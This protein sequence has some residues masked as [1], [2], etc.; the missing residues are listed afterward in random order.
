MLHCYQLSFLYR[1]RKIIEHSEN[2]QATVP[3]YDVRNSIRRISENLVRARDKMN[4]KSPP[5]ARSSPLDLLLNDGKGRQIDH[6]EWLTM[7]ID[8]II[9]TILA[10]IP[11]LK[12]RMHSRKRPQKRELISAFVKRNEQRRKDRQFKRLFSAIFNRHRREIDQIVDPVTGKV[13]ADP[14]ELHDAITS[15]LSGWHCLNHSDPETDWQ[16]AISDP[17]YLQSVP[18]LQKVPQP[19]LSKLAKSFTRHSQNQKLRDTMKAAL[20]Q[21]VSYEEY[22]SE[23]RSKANNKSPGL[24]GFTINMLKELPEEVQRHLHLGLCEI[25][26]RREDPTMVPESWYARWIC[27]VPKKKNGPIT[28]DSIR[29][30]SLYEVLRKVW[31][32]IITARISRV[33]TELQVLHPTQYGYQFAMGTDTELLQIINVI[34]DAAEFKKRLILTSFDTT[35]AFDSVNKPLMVAAWC[36]LGVPQ[37]I[38]NYLVNMD[39]GGDTLVK[40]AHAKSV[41][42][43][44]KK[45]QHLRDVKVSGEDAKSSASTVQTFTARDGIG[46]GDSPS[47]NAWIAIYDILLCALDEIEEDP[48]RFQ[49]RD[50]EVSTC[51]AAAYADDLQTFSPTVEHA[52]AAIDIVSAFNCVTGF[53]TNI[54]KMHCGT[55]LDENLG[56]VRV[57]DRHWTG[58]LLPIELEME[59]VILG[60]TID[61]TNRWRTLRQEIAQKTS[62]ISLPLSRKRLSIETKRIAYEMV[63][64]PTILY[65]AK[66][67]NLSLDEYESLLN[68]VNALLRSINR[69]KRTTPEEILYTNHKTAAGL[70][71]SN[72]VSRVQ[73]FKSGMFTRAMRMGNPARQAATAIIE[74]CFRQQAI[75]YSGRA[76]ISISEHN[77]SWYSSLLERQTSCG[78]RL[79]RNSISSSKYASHQPI[80]ELCD[81]KHLDRCD[82]LLAQLDITTVRDLT[83]ET[84]GQPFRRWF[85]DHPVTSLLT[86]FPNIPNN[87]PNILQIGKL[88]LSASREIHEF[89]GWEGDTLYFREWKTRTGKCPSVNDPILLVA[90]PQHWEKRTDAF[91]LDLLAHVYAFGRTNKKG[92]VTSTRIWAIQPDSTPIRQ[93]TV[94]RTP[95]PLPPPSP[96]FFSP[97][98]LFT[99][100]AHRSLLSAQQIVFGVLPCDLSGSSD[101]SSALRIENSSGGV[102]YKGRV[103]IQTLTVTGFDDDSM[104]NSSSYES[105]AIGLLAGLT[106]LG[107]NALKVAAY[108][109]SSVLLGKLRQYRIKATLEYTADPLI[110]R[111]HQMISRYQVELNWVKGHPERRA[112]LKRKDWSPMD[113]GIYIADQMTKG[114][115]DDLAPLRF[116]CDNITPTVIQFRDLL[117][118]LVNCT[119]YQYRRESGVPLAEYQMRLLQQQKV[120]ADYLRNREHTSAALRKILWTQLSIPLAVQALEHNR[121]ISKTRTAKTVFDLYDDDLHKAEE[122]LQYCPLCQSEQDTT[123]H[124]FV[125]CDHNA[126]ALVAYALVEQ[127]KFPVPQELYECDGISAAQAESLRQ[128]VIC[129]I[130]LDAQTRIGLFNLKQQTD[131]VSAIP[132]LHLREDTEKL[133]GV[134]SRYIVQ[135]LQ[136]TVSATLGLIQ[137]RNAKKKDLERL[138]QLSDGTK[139]ETEKKKRKYGSRNPFQ[140]LFPTESRVEPIPVTSYEICYGCPSVTVQVV[141]RSAEEASN[142]VSLLTQIPLHLIKFYRRSEEHSDTYEQIEGLSPQSVNFVSSKDSIFSPLL[143]FPGGYGL[144]NFNRYRIIRHNYPRDMHTLYLTKFIVRLERLIVT[145]HLMRFFGFLRRCSQHAEE[146]DNR[147]I[148]RDVQ[149]IQVSVLHRESLSC[150]LLHQFLIWA[151]EADCLHRIVEYA[152]ISGIASGF[153]SDLM[154]EVDRKF[155]N[156]P[157][158]ARFCDN[159]IVV[160]YKHAPSVLPQRPSRQCKKRPQVIENDC[161]TFDQCRTFHREGRHEPRIS[162]FPSIP[163]PPSLSSEEVLHSI[164]LSVKPLFS[165]YDRVYKQN[166]DV[167]DKSMCQQII[168]DSEDLLRDDRVSNLSSI[169]RRYLRDKLRR[170]ITQVRAIQQEATAY[171]PTLPSNQCP[172][173]NSI[174]PF[175]TRQPR[176]L[177][178]K[179][180]PD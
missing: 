14:I 105:E 129:L 66:F 150:E 119:R 36:R 166:A 98:R 97:Y 60:V 135:L 30:I 82:T 118:D 83:A 145:K 127:Q 6:G 4:E 178:N 151:P 64:L 155:S 26:S 121:A 32:S 107:D 148:Q 158:I 134:I 172:I 38:A 179:D 53:T 27:S 42:G 37:D 95:A 15:H 176:R 13:T 47:A 52:Q 100:G 56:E 19:L 149:A 124:L 126:V 168:S 21:G 133:L 9:P 33:W 162:A 152:V 142:T 75:N 62:E 78:T 169:H 20:N 103:P 24:S 55:N 67:I 102:I 164:H 70:K 132:G 177:D 143:L 137:L 74:R 92:V 18:S 57:H 156:L 11:S 28:L 128:T 116:F 85:V 51:T 91:C 79:Y 120:A 160:Y 180:P 139:N 65:K 23:V 89:C 94:L 39:V 54:E 10:V 87:E 80:R 29:P 48:Y 140:L 40:T 72:I 144:H 49:K 136:P 113:I 77:C 46:Q 73:D 17:N 112:K 7:N 125:C 16:R 161:N 63:V 45:G 159:D 157:Q 108:T 115:V 44:L 35:K 34:E 41:I 101:D 5:G 1:L 22:M 104:P 109:D 141:A 106:L 154:Y 31:T 84:R 88:Y 69:L 43:K 153:S 167:R 146:T 138:K 130:N 117:P 99:D 2:T 50:G 90:D 110:S 59:V 165:R 122:Y 93:E 96:T 163:P 58:H 131:I 86:S 170:A 71:L 114:N 81:P 174:L 12:K 147:H 171:D 68:P 76:D 25:W 3:G 175:L 123:E 173:V 111:L 8:Q 61:L